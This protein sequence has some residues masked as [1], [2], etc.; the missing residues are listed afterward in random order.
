VPTPYGTRH[1]VRELKESFE[2]R[3]AERPPIANRRNL[4]PEPRVLI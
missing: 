4:P 1:A 2:L 3:F